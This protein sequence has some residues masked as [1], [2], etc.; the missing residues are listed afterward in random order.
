M[1]S[2]I[3]NVEAQIDLGEVKD[4]SLCRTTPPERMPVNFDHATGI[5]PPCTVPESANNDPKP[6][7]YL[8]TRAAVSARDP[9]PRCMYM[10]VYK[11]LS[12]PLLCFLLSY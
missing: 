8:S 11:S 1:G 4:T 7:P 6:A 5:C 2:P 12:W 3:L 10:N 9:G